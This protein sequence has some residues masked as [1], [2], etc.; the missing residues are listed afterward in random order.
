VDVGTPVE[1]KVGHGDVGGF[2]GDL[3]RR[4]PIVLLRRSLRHGVDERRVIFKMGRDGGKVASTDFIEK[5]LHDTE[6][7]AA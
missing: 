1:K 2:D 3:K 6:Y 5:R 7:R 4:L